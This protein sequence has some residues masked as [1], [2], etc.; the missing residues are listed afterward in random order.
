MRESVRERVRRPSIAVSTRVALPGS[1][2]GLSFIDYG[3]HDRDAA[4]IQKPNNHREWM[5]IKTTQLAAAEPDAAAEGEAGEGQG[6]PPLPGIAPPPPPPTADSA[7]TGKAA[8][9]EITNI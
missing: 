1:I 3:V 2:D 7:E 9:F 4:G 8:A 5:I 6:F